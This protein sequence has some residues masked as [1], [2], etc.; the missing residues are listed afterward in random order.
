[1]VETITVGSTDHKIFYAC[2]EENTY[3]VVLNAN[4]GLGTS[5]TT[6]PIL[7][8]GNLPANTFERAGYTFKGWTDG[9]NTYSDLAAIADIIGTAN[10]DNQ[11]TL[12]AVWE[13]NKYSITYSDWNVGSNAN[14]NTITEYSAEL[15]GDIV[16]IDPAIKEEG[17]QFL[18]WYDGDTKVTTIQ[19]TNEKDYNL[20]AKWAHSGIFNIKYVSRS[21][22]NN[23]TYAAKFTV[24]RTF[25][26]DKVVATSAP[27]VVYVRTANGTAYGST[28]EVATATAQDKYHFVHVNPT[29]EGNGI[30][31]FSQDD[32]SKTVTI[33]E[34]DMSTPNDIVATYQLN[35]KTRY[36]NVQIYKVVDSTG[37]C[38]GVLG[39]TVK[40]K[41]D[42]GY[43]SNQTINTSTFFKE[44]TCNVFRWDAN[45]D[46]TIMGGGNSSYN[47]N[48]PY[49]TTFAPTHL[50]A[51]DMTNSYYR[52]YYL[53]TCG[54]V[55]FRF[56]ANVSPDIFDN[57]SIKFYSE[58][59]KALCKEYKISKGMP[60]YSAW[61]F[62]QKDD[63]WASVQ[64]GDY[65]YAISTENEIY[66]IWSTE[67]SWKNPR[68]Y[69]RP[70]DNT[71]P[72]QV[73]IAPMAFTDY[74]AGEKIQITVNF[75]EIIYSASNATLKTI[76]GL[77]IKDVKYVDG[78]NTNALTFEATVT[79]D[80]TVTV[81]LNNSLVN[82]KAFKGT[83][84][85]IA[86]NSR[87]YN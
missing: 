8:T 1:A 25:P 73:G 47:I 84:K 12:T 39:N 57:G 31:T 13:I 72:Q 11:V 78:V 7:Y 81:N 42:L 35:N 23:G 15:E 59:N 4:D 41:R 27:Q 76:N 74:K 17:Y 64:Y 80:F 79:S 82:T 56:G 46:S 48:W 29:K 3:T 53:A 9:V 62:P 71:A 69:V 68:V 20:V 65:W 50:Y 28:P 21:N 66:S 26:S 67:V 58:T 24:T 18:G 37:V 45:A 43:N 55:A 51:S 2:W 60:T 70:Y 36:Y 33:T 14:P 34:N 77:P 63:G 52:N 6:E 40:V 16:L 54:K 5:I 87:T 75:N 10:G 19:K 61:T 44:Y 86:S 38:N 32:T 30:V 49:S 83:V 85:D 22:N